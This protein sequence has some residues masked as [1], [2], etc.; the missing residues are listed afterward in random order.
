MKIVTVI[1]LDKS[2]RASEVWGRY[3]SIIAKA[4]NTWGE[5]FKTNSYKKQ[6]KHSER[7][8]NRGKLLVSRFIEDNNILC[9]SYDI[10][11]G[12]FIEIHIKLK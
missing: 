2:E 7:L 9:D 5:V 12:E 8:L 1:Y 3:F 6:M 10:K 4:H 11:K